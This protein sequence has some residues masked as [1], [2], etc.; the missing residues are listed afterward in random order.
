MIFPLLLVQLADA[1]SYFPKQYEPFRSSA[2]DEL[3]PIPFI[4]DGDTGIVFMSNI[5]LP[6]IQRSFVQP[7]GQGA[8]EAPMNVYFFNQ[9]ERRSAKNPRLLDPAGR[10]LSEGDNGPVTATADFKKICIVQP[11]LNAAGDPLE[12]G[13]SGLFFSEWMDGSWTDPV[14]FSHNDPEVNYSTPCLSPDGSL[15]FFAAEGDLEGAM[16]GWD[17]YYSM[18]MGDSW[19]EPL[20]IGERINTPEDEIF[21]FYHVSESALGMNMRLYFSSKGHNSRGGY[22][23]FYSV[24]YD[25]EWLEPLPVASLNSAGTDEIG[26]YVNED[27]DEGMFT[28]RDGLNFTI[29]DFRPVFANYVEFNNAGPMR[30]AP[31]CY[32]IFESTM[33]TVDYDVFSYEWVINKEIHLPGHEVRYCFPGPGYYSI[34]FNVTNKLTDTIMYNAAH[35]DLTIPDYK[36][37]IIS[38]PDTVN[39][40]EP[41]YFGAS[42]SNL[43]EEWTRVEYF[44]DYGDLSA[45]GRGINTY[46]TYSQQGKYR[47]TLGARKVL[48][49]N[50][51]RA[52]RNNELPES[53]YKLAVYK[54][55][56]VLDE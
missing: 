53:E 23:L 47:V 1:Q 28:R 52:V 24:F 32:R 39:V 31:L 3:A 40:G 51:E 34:A 33:D 8:T 35:I 46:H 43:P 30:K 2:N 56:L 49:R 48:N 11:Q 19:S 29:W 36:Q 6:S 20:N 41:V 9:G 12:N 13:N 5:T 14:F 10:F 37:P 16:G 45:Q 44:W 22:D 18:N 42:E 25:G 54:D 50:E 4:L 21:P 7:A 55:I 15:L 17:I 27:L 38:A 26:I